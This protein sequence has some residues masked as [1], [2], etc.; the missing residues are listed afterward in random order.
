MGKTSGFEKALTIGTFGY[1]APFIAAK[2]VAKKAIDKQKDTARQ[3]KEAAQNSQTQII[4]E[5]KESRKKSE[6][7]LGAAINKDKKT[8]GG[9]ARARQRQRASSAGGRSSTILAGGLGNI[10]EPPTAR[11]TLLGA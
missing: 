6:S 11:K 5:I 10:N 1:A 4:D 7:I 2:K 9:A 8:V 3:A